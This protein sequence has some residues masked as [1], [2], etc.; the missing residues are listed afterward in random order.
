METSY[1]LK[2]FKQGRYEV[3]EV[4]GRGLF[5]AVYKVYDTED[6]KTYALKVLGLADHDRDIAEAMFNKEVDA[7]SGFKNDGVVQMV[8]HF[9]EAK[10]GGLCIVLELIPRAVTLE[11]IIREVR[12]GTRERLSV[13]WCLEQLQQLIT[14]LD[15]A[16]NRHVVHRDV[17]P[18]NLLVGQ[19]GGKTFTKLADF[20]IARIVEHYGRDKG[21]TLPQFATVPY[22]PPE[23]VKLL[24]TTVASDYYAFGVTMVALL[25][26]QLPKE[27]LEG[28]AL[29][30]FLKPLKKA[31]NDSESSRIVEKLARGLFHPEPQERPRPTTVKRSLENVL[32][33]LTTKPQ[34]GLKVTDSVRAK[35]EKYGMTVPHFFEDLNDYPVAEYQE[36]ER[37]GERKRNVVFHGRSVMV[38]SV[39]DF[40]DPEQ[41]VLVD[42]RIEQPDFHRR[43]REGENVH[44]CPYELV[45]GKGSAYGLLNEFYEYF[46]FGRASKQRYEAKEDLLEAGLFVLGHLEDDAVE[47]VITYRQRD[48]QLDDDILTVEVVNVVSSNEDGLETM[49]ALDDELI[50]DWI[51]A[52]GESTIFSL[53]RQG[54]KRITSIGTLRN[55]NRYT[56]ELSL[57]T[58]YQGTIPPQGRLVCQ[59][60]AQLSSN[61]RQRDAVDRFLA[62]NTVNQQLGELLLKPG[63]NSVGE[64]KPRQLIQRLEPQ[65][66]TLSILERALAAE[67]FFLVQGPPGTGK[68]TLI[69]E[70]VMQVL[71]EKPEARIL[72]TSQANPAVDNALSR[73]R[74]LSESHNVQLRTL[75]LTRAQLRHGTNEFEDFFSTW[76]EETREA[77]QKGLTEVLETLEPSQRDKVSNAIENWQEKLSWADDVRKDYAQSVQVYGVT[78]LR[79]PTLWELL[80]KVEFDWVIVDEAAKATDTEVLVPLVH[81]KRFF[82][83][84]DQRQLPP[85]IDTEIEREMRYQGI[86]SEE[87]RSSLF[88]K[89]FDLLPPSNKATLRRQYR[90]HRS[91]GDFVGRLFYADIGGLETGVSDEERQLDIDYLKDYEHRVLWFDVASGEEEQPRGGTSF[92]NRSEANKINRILEMFNENLTR[93]E[94]EYTVGVI[95]PYNAQVDVLS[96]SLVPTSKTWTNLKIEVSTVD[97]FQGREND[98]TIY[99]MVRTKPGGLRFVEDE[100]RLNVSFSRAKR[101]LL[102]FGHRETALTSQT[103]SKAL[104]LIPDKNVVTGG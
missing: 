1:E 20:G 84:G 18:A 80:R 36:S 39:T 67:D 7:L 103:F 53:Q 75:R 21:M 92:Y 99:S 34:V 79:A 49:E 29:E 91:I 32:N 24:E 41:L 50:S 101:A 54:Q 26:W 23:Q 104:R 45:E 52:L 78:C 46:L 93:K 76:I 63:T 57:R 82:M 61:K 40:N 59:N 60:V 44:I 100:K 102:I 31:F 86:N 64:R 43:K 55:Y 58:N 30:H 77:S 73:I 83:V 85:Y 9:I 98:L 16:H 37:D 42:A 66:A 69:A 13:S 4:L 14:V 6:D 95:T 87:T 72:L 11:T 27:T 47:L 88:E 56:R 94:T 70:F 19:R 10:S 65:Q 97:A 51:S 5:S 3:K 89:T 48:K 62:D 12:D 90:M 38:L 22:A 28:E 35:I 15:Q 68:T 81:G 71:K 33:R 2:T 96:E 25:T 74:D 8:D 17:K